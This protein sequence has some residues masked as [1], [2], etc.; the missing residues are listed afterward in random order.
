MWNGKYGYD[1]WNDIHIRYAQAKE[2]AQAVDGIVSQHVAAKAKHIER[3][4]ETLNALILLLKANY[5]DGS[6]EELRRWGFQKE[7]Y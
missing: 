6:R 4:R 3:I 7:K 2:E 1:Y 5:P